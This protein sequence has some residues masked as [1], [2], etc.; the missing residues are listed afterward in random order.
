[1]NQ[2][3]IR[4]YVVKMTYIEDGVILNQMANNLLDAI[5]N[6]ITYKRLMEMIE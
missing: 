3:Q 5:D 4:A 1:M 6:E 2:K